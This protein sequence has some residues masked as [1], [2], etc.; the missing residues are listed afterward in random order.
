MKPITFEC[1]TV[2]P[3]SADEICAEI[4]DVARWSEFDGYGIL[5]G[6]EN[7]AYEIQTANRVGSRIRVRNTDGSAHVEEI[8][9]WIPGQAVALRFHEF[10]PPLSRLAT[11]FTEE[12]ILKAEHGATHVTRRFEM[13]P[14]QPAARP[15]LWLISLL[16]RRAIARH[17]A[18]IAARP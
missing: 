8:I 11:H 2:I 6:I 5:P 18:D 16:F 9:R 4:A 14:S 12:W 15:L 1:Q 13:H 10:T 7:A 3:R 17:L